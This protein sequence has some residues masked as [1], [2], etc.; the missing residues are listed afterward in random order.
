[1]RSKKF[2]SNQSTGLAILAAILI[3]GSSVS[4]AG[5]YP[6]SAQVLAR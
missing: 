1:M 6:Y 5:T 3:V 4:V 2:I